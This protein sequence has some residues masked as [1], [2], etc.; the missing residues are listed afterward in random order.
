MDYRRE[1]KNGKEMSNILCG[2]RELQGGGC[3]M[4]FHTHVAPFKTMKGLGQGWQWDLPDGGEGEQAHA[5]LGHN[6][7]SGTAIVECLTSL[8][9]FSNVIA[10]VCEPCPYRQA[11]EWKGSVICIETAMSKLQQTCTIS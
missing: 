9:F 8:F 10:C 4:K 5:R 3:L 6:P 7:Y 2:A 1:T 11:A